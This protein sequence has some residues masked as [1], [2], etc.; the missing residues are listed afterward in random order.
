MDIKR[1][2]KLQR[3]MPGTPSMRAPFP[4]PGIPPEEL[5]PPPADVS[6]IN[7]KWLDVAYA[8]VSATQQLDIY[9]PEAGEGL[10]PIAIHIH[11]GAFAIGDKRDVQVL[12]F[13][14]G[15]ELGYGVQA[16]VSPLS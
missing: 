8:E 3:G 13:L 2:P 5:Q 9:L 11:G 4:M 15:L 6:Y 10:F 16:L 14:Q 1:K 12:P 7:R